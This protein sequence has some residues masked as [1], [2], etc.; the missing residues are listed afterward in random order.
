[1]GCRCVSGRGPITTW[2]LLPSGGYISDVLKYRSARRQHRAD[3]ALAGGGPAAVRPRRWPP[4]RRRPA[5]RGREPVGGRSHRVLVGDLQHFVDQRHI[6]HRGN[7]SVANALDLVQTG[8]MAE[9]RGGVFGSTATTRAPRLCSLRNFP[10]PC[11]VP[12]LPTPATNAAMSPLIC[13]TVPSPSFRS[14]SADCRGSRTAAARTRGD[15]RRPSAAPARPPRRC[16]P[17]AASGSV[18]RRAPG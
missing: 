13:A 16:R 12:P 6:E 1:M 11:S 9:Q 2:P 7:E 4:R 17:R 5:G 15:P 14:G 10:T 3:V 18:R 8:F